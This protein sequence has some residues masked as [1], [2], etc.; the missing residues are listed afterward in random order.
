MKKAGTFFLSFVPFL[1]SIALQFV[2][3]FYFL[4]IGAIFLLGI[5][6]M[7]TKKTYD[8]DDLMV[9]AAD[10]NFNTVIMIT[11]SVTCIVTLPSLT[12]N[13]MQCYNRFK[14]R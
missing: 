5:G 9:L 14:V 4:I 12:R 6:P 7:I 3:V 1:I 13:S 8:I 11:F 2:I 10:M